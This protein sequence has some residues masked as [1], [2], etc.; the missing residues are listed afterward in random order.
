MSAGDPI[1]LSNKDM[2]KSLQATTATIISNK[3]NPYN[4]HIVP[5]NKYDNYHHG[6]NPT[7][8]EKLDSMNS[9]DGISFATK[10]APPI[11]NKISNSNNVFQDSWG[12]F[13]SNSVE[14]VK[15]VEGI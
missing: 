11:Q 10:E 12:H 6:I 3:S 14:N 8:K 9:H 4:S 5:S 2:S 7:E 1:G 13:P 15:L